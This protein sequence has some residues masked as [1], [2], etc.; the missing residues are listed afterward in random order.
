MVVAQAHPMQCTR[1]IRA[2]SI[3]LH[4]GRQ[5]EPALKAV[6]EQVIVE[7]RR[8][9]RDARRPQTRHRRRAVSACTSCAVAVDATRRM[10][11]VRVAAAAAS[12]A[13][14]KGL[15]VE[16]VCARQAVVDA[17]SDAMVHMRMEMTHVDG[18]LRDD[19][20]R[21]CARRQHGALG[22]ERR[23]VQVDQRGCAAQGAVNGMQ[24]LDSAIDD[25]VI[26]A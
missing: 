18:R 2:R 1:N 12:M 21:D 5:V 25:G 17:D 6:P 16:Q 3:H 22:R 14:R 24:P 26:A 8:A 9:A 13:V 19:H 20:G 7:P 4:L 15:V 11:R 10:N 23:V